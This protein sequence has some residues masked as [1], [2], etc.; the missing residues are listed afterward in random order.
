M[1]LE[2]KEL[3]SS[4]HI[5]LTNSVLTAIPIYWIS[6]LKIPYLVIHDIN[7]LCKKFIRN[8]QQ[9]RSMIRHLV[10]WNMMCRPKRYVGLGVKPFAKMV[11]EVLQWSAQALVHPCE[12]YLLQQKTAFGTDALLKKHRLPLWRSIL[13]LH[14]LFKQC[15][16]LKVGNKSHALF[17]HDIWIGEEPLMLSFPHLFAL[18]NNQYASIAR[19]MTISNPMFNFR[20]PLNSIALKEYQVFAHLL[21]SSTL[22]NIHDSWAWK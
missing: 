6:I 19:F 13:G 16:L 14:W 11:I 22:S 21:L 3:N 7:Y 4:C 2:A 1:W 8:D 5:V 18:A 9:S 17:W 12:G 15:L 10:N 20:R